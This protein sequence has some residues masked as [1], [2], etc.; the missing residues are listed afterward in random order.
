[1]ARAYGH[2]SVQHSHSRVS[3]PTVA[4]GWAVCGERNCPTDSVALR[5]C[6]PLLGRL[7]RRVAPLTTLSGL[8]VRAPA[9]A[10][11]PVTITIYKHKT[12]PTSW[13]SRTILHRRR[14]ILN[15]QITWRQTIL[16]LFLAIKIDCKYVWKKLW[17]KYLSHNRWIIY[18]SRNTDRILVYTSCNALCM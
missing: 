16:I 13:P 7:R 6:P 4:A 14:A 15:V 18:W 17:R 5:Q 12:R 2:T 11:S 1:M 9:T 3:R 8:G 10:S